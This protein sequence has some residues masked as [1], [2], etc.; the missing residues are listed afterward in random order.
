MA[1]ASDLAFRR[2]FPRIM[3]TWDEA[4]GAILVIGG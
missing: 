4:N 2:F 3:E 1:P